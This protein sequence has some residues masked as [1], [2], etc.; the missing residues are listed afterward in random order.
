MDELWIHH[1]R[2]KEGTAAG[3][4]AWYLIG[5]EVTKGTRGT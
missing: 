3:R 4:T 2:D 5:Q 1:K